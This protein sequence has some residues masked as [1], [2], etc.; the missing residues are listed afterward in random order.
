MGITFGTMSWLE[1]GVVMGLV[2]GILGASAGAWR[3]GTSLRPT[4]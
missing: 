2:M 3:R 1:W 4:W